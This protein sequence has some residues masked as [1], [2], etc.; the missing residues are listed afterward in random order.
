MLVLKQRFPDDGTPECRNMKERK[1]CIKCV[2]LDGVNSSPYSQKPATGPYCQPNELRH[3]SSLFLHNPLNIIFT[4]ML[5]VF[6]VDSFIQI[7]P[8]KPG[9]HFSFPHMCHTTHPSPPQGMD[10]PNNIWW[11][12]HIKELL[13][14]NFYQSPVT[15]FLL[16]PNTFLSTMFSNTLSLCCSHTVS[17]PYKITDKPTVL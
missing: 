15:S 7:S 11:W 1:F 14:N 13:N 17:H 16:G 8:Q 6:Q 3:L 2:W 10:Q 12:V 4:G 9:I 5:R